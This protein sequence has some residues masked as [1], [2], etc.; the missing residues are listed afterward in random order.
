[1][2][3][4]K[5]NQQMVNRSTDC[6][7]SHHKIVERGF[8]DR[9]EEYKVPLSDGFASFQPFLRYSLEIDKGSLAGTDTAPAYRA[10][11]ILECPEPLPA[12]RRKWEND[13][14]FPACETSEN[15]SL[16]LT[17]IPIKPQRNYKQKA[18]TIPIDQIMGEAQQTPSTENKMSNLC[19]FIINQSIKPNQQS[20]QSET[21]K[22]K[23]SDQSEMVRFKTSDKSKTLRIK[24]SDQSHAM[25]LNTFDQSQ[26]VR[27][28][29]SEKSKTLRLKAKP[30]V[31]CYTETSETKSCLPLKPQRSYKGRG[32]TPISMALQPIQGHHYEE[33]F[34]D[35]KDIIK[36]IKD[37]KPQNTMNIENVKNKRTVLSSL[38]LFLA[39][40]YEGIRDP[41][42][43]VNLCRNKPNGTLY[44]QNL[45]II[46]Q[47][48]DG[49]GDE[50]YV[51]DNN[52]G[53]QTAISQLK[54]GRKKQK[55]FNMQNVPTLLLF[56]LIYG[57]SL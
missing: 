3:L 55:Q 22:L 29:T 44:S 20:E 25:R 19:C 11:Q 15:E 12:M 8:S 33:A 42:R 7:V 18:Q 50:N 51:E 30:V 38:N 10:Q 6:E 48:G 9:V 43:V 34:K 1:M 16:T 47:D 21:L 5:Q 32:V 23:E 56:N 46:C 36:T 4:L 39:L 27:F 45:K 14:H 35:I 57:R 2:T 54:C 17:T 31:Q 24:T 13:S 41:T 52:V 40:T 26:M 49:D 28:K 37:N 53:V